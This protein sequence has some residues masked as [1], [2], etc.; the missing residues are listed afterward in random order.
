MAKKHEAGHGCEETGGQKR[1]IEAQQASAYGGNRYYRSKTV[2]K[3]VQ[4]EDVPQNYIKI[5]IILK[6]DC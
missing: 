3:V 4:K 1:Q 2:A 6:S 5:I